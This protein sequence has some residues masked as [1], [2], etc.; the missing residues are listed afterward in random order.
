MTMG[1]K[2][3][4]TAKSPLR[5]AKGAVVGIVAHLIA[6][7]IFAGMVG[8]NLSYLLAADGET[9][10]REG[11]DLPAF[12]PY[13]LAYGLAAMLQIASLAAYG[14]LFLMWVH[15]TNRNAH[16]LAGGMGTSPGWAVGWFFV[17]LVSLWKPFHALDQ[18]WRV[19]TEPSR[20]RALDTPFILRLWW[21]FYLASNVTGWA[22]DVLRQERTVKG[23]LAAG[24]V[25]IVSAGLIIGA[26][27]LL[28]RIIRTLTARQV[29][30]LDAAAFN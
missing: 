3:L 20:W 14:V 17:P 8:M 23:H 26:G 5:R 27:V 22:S 15:R 9:P 2:R 16:S 11:F 18:T 29:S 19:S 25:A 4:Y 7:A 6:V 28:I 30:S 10:L 13:A 1:K 24:M 12:A 21:G